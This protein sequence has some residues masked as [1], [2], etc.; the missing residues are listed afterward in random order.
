MTRDPEK[1]RFDDDLETTLRRRLDNMDRH[2][3]PDDG[4]RRAA[5]AVVV[6]PDDDG[7]ACL[8]LTRRADHL[9][10]HSGQ[11]A[12]PG[13]RIDPG[14]TVEE[15]ALR[16]L[17]EEV[18]LELEAS[19]ILGRLDDFVTRSGYHM[20]AVAVWGGRDAVLTP[21]PG[22]V[23]AV[24]RVPVSV[25]ADPARRHFAE[26]LIDSRE[27]I[28]DP[29]NSSRDP[30]DLETDRPM[31]ALEIV[32]TWVFA[33]TAAILLQMAELTA[34]GRVIRVAHYEQPQFAW[35]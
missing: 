5:V 33:P 10:R 28:D 26:G 23:A 18:D 11:Y 22:E 2:A 9:G 25:L 31:L 34:H 4:Q 8:V 6:V 1:V 19:Q 3:L 14:E 21:D 29:P 13:G 7:N 24:H 15:A 30:S 20:A 32:D 12:L 27:S 16:E 35:S 17:H